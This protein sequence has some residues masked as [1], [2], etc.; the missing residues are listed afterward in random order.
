MSA[1][2]PEANEATTEHAEHVHRWRIGE[3]GGPTSAGVCECGEQR[4]FTNT[5]ITAGR[6][7]LTPGG[8]R[9]GG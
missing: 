9:P 8:R 1:E 2:K 6:S 5:V 7:H 3:Q 4:A